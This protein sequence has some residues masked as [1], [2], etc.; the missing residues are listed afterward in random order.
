MRTLFLALSRSE[1]AG[2]FLTRFGMTRRA[3][4][5][6]MAGETLEEAVQAVK[7]LNERGARVTLNCLGENVKREEDARAARDEYLNEL[8]TLAEQ[9]LDANISVKLTQLGL[10]ISPELCY[11]MTRD[12]L[13]EA[14]TRGR[15]IE[16]DMEGSAYTETTLDLACR[17]QDEI[18]GVGLAVQAYLYRTAGDIERLI[19]T[20]VKIRLVKGAYQEPPSVAFPRKKQV[21]ENYRRLMDRLFDA[22]PAF[23]VA[24]HDS[25][26][27]AHA[28]QRLENLDLGDRFFEFQMIYGI[29]RDLQDR[30]LAQK[31]P[32][33]V[34]VPYGR[35]WYP[36][37]MRRLAER[38]ANV[39]FVLKHLFRA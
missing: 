33:R 21:D 34:Y 26:L 17:L 35:H 22:A 5:R 29:R 27:L 16:I 14:R 32:L 19:K 11:T 10:D 7:A 30:I 39:G 3:V 23:A 1:R 8:R 15:D 20:G 38:P 37:F 6:F 4:R 36:Y 13:Q 24:T 25:R 18:G 12:I 31:R 9:N 2:R 28:F